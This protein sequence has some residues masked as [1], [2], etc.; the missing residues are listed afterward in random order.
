[1]KSQK[2]TRS[3]CEVMNNQF[4]LGIVELRIDIGKVL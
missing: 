1:M 3:F 2:E 4:G